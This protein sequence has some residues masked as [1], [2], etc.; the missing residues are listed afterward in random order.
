MELCFRQSFYNYNKRFRLL[1]YRILL[2]KESPKII[3]LKTG[4]KTL[5][6]LNEYFERNWTSIINAISH[7][8]M[9]IAYE[10][11]IEIVN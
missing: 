6:E 10:N 3:Y 5:K 7:S 4:N 2:E 1:F 11:S 9:V 8:K